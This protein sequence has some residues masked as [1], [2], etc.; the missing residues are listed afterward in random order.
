MTL[1]LYQE[2]FVEFKEPFKRIITIGT[3]LSQSYWNEEKRKYISRNDVSYDK[4]N[5]KYIDKSDPS[6]TILTQLEKM[7]KSKLNGV[8]PLNVL[9][10]SSRDILRLYVTLACNPKISGAW[11]E[12]QFLCV[13]RL[14][15]TWW[16][17]IRLIVIKNADLT[18]RNVMD[19]ESRLSIFY[20]S[21]MPKSLFSALYTQVV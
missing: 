21:T 8:S 4:V 3:L 12:S 7:S 11:D 13:N 2:N 10:D 15:I 6:A 9:S 5:K 19:P 14:I 20:V 17:I 18:V 1:F 16:D